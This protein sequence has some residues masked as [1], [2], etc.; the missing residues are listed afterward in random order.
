MAKNPKV[1]AYIADAAPFARPILKHFRSL[2]HRACPEVQED[3]KWGNPH[4]VHHG[5]LCFMAAFKAHCA[6]GF[7][8]PEVHRE[9]EA[10][11]KGPKRLRRVASMDELPEEKRLIRWIKISAAL[12]K[13]GVKRQMRGK[14]RPA[15]KTPAVLA[16]ALKGN[17]AAAKTFQ[18]LSKS[19][20]NEYIEWITEAKTN[21]TRDK[22]LA[23]TLEWLAQGRAR[24]W[25]YR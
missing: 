15:L 10:A 20:R 22:R 16:R 11:G 3:I 23:T 25:K 17:A 18:D 9:I 14:P 4:F 21:A 6:I 12:N 1:D 8:R 2:I 19:G 7:W 13:A 24:N 5:M